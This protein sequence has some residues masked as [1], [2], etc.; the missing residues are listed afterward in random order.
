MFFT[1]LP[2]AFL[3]ALLRSA[4]CLLSF[5]FFAFLC[6]CVNHAPVPWELKSSVCASSDM[7]SSIRSDKN[8]QTEKKKEKKMFLAAS[9]FA[10]KNQKQLTKVGFSNSYS[11]SSSFPAL[12]QVI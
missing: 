5:Y 8:V 1:C 12:H 6:V 3:A 10:Q 2:Y 11:C 9:G 7:G 4:L